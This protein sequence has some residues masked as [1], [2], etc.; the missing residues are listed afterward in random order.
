MR[1]QGSSD[2]EACFNCKLNEDVVVPLNR[3]IE[4]VQSVEELRK[5]YGIKIGVFGHCGDGNLHVNMMYNEENE[6]E[7]DRAVSALR[8]LMSQVISLGGAISGEHGVGLAK[9]PFV[10][11]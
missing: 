9:T 10:R 8:E 7:T 6:E 11:E 3:Q 4:L 1:R 2:E 5:K